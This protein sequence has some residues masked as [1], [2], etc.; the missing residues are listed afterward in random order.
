[1]YD[2]EKFED[3]PLKSKINSAALINIRLHNLWNDTHLH[4]RKGDYASWN[5]DLDRV[6]CELA[7]DVKES[8]TKETKDTTKGKNKTEKFQD[9]Q[10]KL[11]KINP[12]L[13]WNEIKGFQELSKEQK[14][15]QQAQYEV[16]MD[17]EIFLRQ[18]QNEQ[19]KGTAYWDA[20]EDYMDG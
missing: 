19:G 8:T 20:A 7:A 1:M 13:K 3:L 9:L 2:E 10:A 14:E 15:K 6:W 4:S 18:L 17:K 16:L 5:A 12:I 11:K